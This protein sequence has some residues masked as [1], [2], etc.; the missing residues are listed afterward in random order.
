M[1]AQARRRYEIIEILHD[2]V[3][4]TAKGCLISY[5]DAKGQTKQV[6]CPEINYIFG[7]SEYFKETLD[8]KS[9]TP[10]GTQLKFPCIALFCPIVEDRTNPDYYTT[11]KVKLLIACSTKQGWSNAQRLNTSFRGILRPIYNRFIEALKE[12]GRLDFGYDGSMPHKYSENYS[13]GRYGAY[14]GS[15]EAVSEPI[16]A[17]DI[18]NLELKVKQPNCR[19]Q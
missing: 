18:S 12:D 11:A 15:G 9:L 8:E 19:L 3:K 17:I 4:A 16:D 5:M 6:E 14:T 7:N 10:K 2:V 1:R 13:Y